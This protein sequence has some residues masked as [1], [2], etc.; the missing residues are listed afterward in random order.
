MN[1]HSASKTIFEISFSVIFKFYL[2]VKRLCD[3]KIFSI[4]K[5]I[6][7][8]SLRLTLFFSHP[9]HNR[10]VQSIYISCSD[11][12]KNIKFFI[13][14]FF[15]CV[16]KTAYFFLF[17]FYFFPITNQKSRLLLAI[18]E[19]DIYLIISILLLC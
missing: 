5:I 4:F 13:F 16:L 17:T 8:R 18:H 14:N 7:L 11:C 3:R 1:S 19:L 12:K 10:I 15:K 2:L 9:F 6:L